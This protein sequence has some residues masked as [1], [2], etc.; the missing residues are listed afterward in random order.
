MTLHRAVEQ[1]ITLKRSLGFRF[2]S[3]SVILVA[4]S[5]AIGKVHLRQVKSRGVASA[6]SSH[7]TRTHW[8]RIT[9]NRAGVAAPA[10]WGGFAH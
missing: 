2:Q 8:P 6:A 5:K 3:E 10:L 9:P 1:Y 7:H 4:F